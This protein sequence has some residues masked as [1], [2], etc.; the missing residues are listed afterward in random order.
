MKAWKKTIDFFVRPHIWFLLLVVLITIGAIV[1]ASLFLSLG[2]L[3]DYKAWG[4]VFLGIMGVGASYTVY[5]VIKT[6][7]EIKSRV[8]SWAERHPFWGRAV[9]EYGFRIIL[10]SAL[11]FVINV[12]FAV[13]N[14]VVAVL[15]SSIWFGALAA[16]YIL[17]IL[18]RGAILI[19]HA[20]RGRAVK[21]GTDKIFLRDTKIY[22][23]CGAILILLP[24]AL[25]F[26]IL[27]MVRFDDSFVHTGITIYAYAAYVFFKITM[28]IYNLVKT[29]KAKE[30]TVRASNC[31]NLADAMVSVLALQTA[32]FREFGADMGSTVP[33]MNATVGGVVCTLTALLGVI[34][35]FV[36]V[37]TSRRA[38]SDYSEE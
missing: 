30:M 2:S 36:A 32:M 13:Y 8:L 14:G 9:H 1:G 25:S 15:I 4:Y 37:R 28:A 6:Y 24:V 11:S 31:I 21:R 7:P 26:A 38:Q 27:Q 17:L 34:M 20:W 3:A 10:I 33:I 29:R 35:I 12:A 18:L 16:Y 23:I 5:G 19:Y 22:G